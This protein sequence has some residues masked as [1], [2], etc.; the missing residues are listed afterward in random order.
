MARLSVGKI[1]SPRPHRDP[2]LVAVDP[3]AR[4]NFETARK[5]ATEDRIRVRAVRRQALK[6]TSLFDVREV[7]RLH[8]KLARGKAPESLAS[9]RYMRG[10]RRQLAGALWELVRRER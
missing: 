10:L 1:R 5:A 9:A 4:S 6:S 8:R 3:D 2:A 7:R